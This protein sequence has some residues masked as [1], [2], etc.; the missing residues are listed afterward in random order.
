MIGQTI[1]ER[2][3]IE[4]LIDRGGMGAVYRAT[5]VVENRPVALKFLH[6]FLDAET[7]V[8]QTRFRREFRVLARLD[9]P[10]IVRAYEYGTY[11]DVPYLVL[12][13]LAG[14]TLTEEVATGPLSRTRLLLVARQICEALVYLHAQSIVHR[15]LKP[16]NLMLLPPDDSPL[17]KLMDFGLVRAANLSQQLTQEGVALGT[18]AYMAPEQAQA[19]PVDFRADL[20]ALGVILYEMATGRPPFI[21]ENPAMMLMQQLT[22]APPPPRQFKP[23]LDE[24]LEQLIL[25]LLVKEPAQRPVS[26]ELV[27]T[28]LAHLAN[29]RAPTIRAPARR[30]DIIPHVPLIGRETALNELIQHW[31]KVQASTLSEAGQVS[32][33]RG[34][35]VLLSGAAGAGKTRLLTEASLQGQ[36]DRHQFKTAH[37]R[38]YASLPYQAV[39]DVL[40][41]LLPDLPAAGREA[42]PVELIRLLPGG[43][44]NVPDE[45]GTTDQVEARRRLFAGC[46][47]VLQQAAQTRPL[48]IVI[49]DVHWADPTTL[50]LLGYLAD[51]AAQAPVLLVLTYQPEEVEPNAP[52][53]TLRRDLQRSEGVYEI[54][55]EP[56]SL[57]QVA[58]FLRAT[59][60]QAHVPTWLVDSFHL[61]TGGNPFFIEETLKAL[62]AEGQVAEWLGRQS[63]Q[64]TMAG[65]ALQLPQNVLALAERRLQLLSAEDRPI[66]TAAAVLGPEFTFALLEGVTQL[67]E[68]TLLDAIERLLAARLIEEL[69][70]RADEDRYRFAQE[71]LRQA[72]LGTI[73]QRRLRVLHRRTGE[74]IEALYGANHSDHWPALAYHWHQAENAPKAIDYMQKAGEQAGRNYAI[75]EAA[76]FFNQALALLK[77]L[78]DTIEHTQ[79]ELELQIALAQALMATKGYGAL[80][81]GQ[82]FNRAREL[83]EQIGETSQLF[84]VLRGL[85]YFHWARAELVTGQE[86]AEQ[87]L[88]LAR[89]AGDPMLLLEAHRTLGPTL[90]WLGRFA[91]AREHLERGIAL[92]DPQQHYAHA[93]LYGQDPGVLC[94]AYVAWILWLLGYPDQALGRSQEALSLVEKLGHPQSTALAL[95]WAGGTHQ[96]RREGPAV[97]KQAEAAITFSTKQGFEFWVAFGTFLR[98]WA[99]AEQ[100]QAEEGIDQMRQGLTAWRATGAELARPYCLSLLV[101]AYAKVGQIEQGLTLL[102]EAMTLVDETGERWWEAELY[103][104]KGELGLNDERG[105]MNDEVAPEAWFLKAIGIA[106]QQ[107]AKSLELRAT[108][109]LARLWQGQGKTAEARE[110]LAEIYGWFTEGFDTADLIEAKT[111]LDELA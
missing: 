71:S 82:A 77:T 109:S 52:L 110:I 65:P 108:V 88:D 59:L 10:G 4:V 44:S 7:Q 16:G 1:A 31:T 70:L 57:E 73:S 96:L 55:L 33:G 21:H 111:L 66:L 99:L 74:T 53:A 38:E 86:L 75:Q 5:D 20:Y 12:E 81:V 58:D 105:M 13:F 34:G 76:A 8:G 87:L 17:V 64:W 27:G 107:S 69:P 90:F 80:E 6:F 106:R 54:S 37:C 51:H 25:D 50:E 35:T 92:Y 85:C 36:L 61:A 62:A 15:D 43:S 91:P 56:L 97:G 23:D 32:A 67:D 41:A 47:E 98:G 84:T 3:Q 39:I 63:S 78:P 101:E 22:T 79:Q 68:D 11:Q 94:L 46:W 102:V 100:E 49:E 28:R 29:E 93:L 18:V 9:H 30:A 83:C 89:R 95:I 26:T 72:L 48:L 103:R 104:L 14:H 60:G 2:Y 42:L 19:L 45:T 40:D 24:D